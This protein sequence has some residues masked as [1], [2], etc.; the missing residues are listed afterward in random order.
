MTRIAK[1]VFLKL[2]ISE[3]DAD[4]YLSTDEA[5]TKDLKVD[6]ITKVIYDKQV[7]KAKNDG[8]IQSIVSAKIGE[9]L[10]SRDNKIMKEAKAKGVVITDAEYNGLPEKDRT[11]KL[12][13]LVVTKLSEK[14]GANADDK[15]KEIAR[16]NKEYT[17]AL[18]KIKKLE[19]EE[20]PKAKTEAEKLIESMRLETQVDQIYL[21]TLKGKLIGDEVTLKPAV[22]AKVM[23]EYDIKLKDGKLAVF[24]KGKDTLAYEGSN[25][26]TVEKVFTKSAEDIKL[27]K[28]QEPVVKKKIESGNDKTENTPPALKR[29]LSQLEQKKSEIEAA[30]Q[31]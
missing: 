2:G 23:G 28:A 18:D 13:E 25:P 27:V 16:L 10:S 11:D 12:I 1:E 21:N 22:M 14:S 31:G 15:D 29:A 5:V 8:T 9:V 17:D 3:A 20:L 19:E 7:D 30:K 26:L 6:D 24:N 4:K